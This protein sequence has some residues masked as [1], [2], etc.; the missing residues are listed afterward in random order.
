[1]V[2]EDSGGKA[3]SLFADAAQRVRGSAH[4]RPTLRRVS[5]GCSDLSD[6]PTNGAPVV[7]GSLKDTLFVSRG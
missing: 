6:A 3:R 2:G 4:D 7:H 1:M 5:K